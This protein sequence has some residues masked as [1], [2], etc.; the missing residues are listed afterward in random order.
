MSRS[1]RRLL[2]GTLFAVL[3]LA[4]AASAEVRGSVPLNEG[5]EFADQPEGPWRSIQVPHVMDPRPTPE[6][7]EGRVAWYRLR[8]TGPR[9]EGKSWW[10]RFDQVRRRAEAFLNGRP[11]GTN[12][13]PY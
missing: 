7:W 1:V 11:I 9:A 5:W 6:V 3:L 13:D 2:A 12:E 8:F 4:P 10:L